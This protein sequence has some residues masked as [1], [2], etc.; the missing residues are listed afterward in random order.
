MAVNVGDVAT[1]LLLVT[2]VAV[3]RPP[4]VPVAPEA[5]AVKVTVAPFTGLLPASFTVACIAV[6]NAVL[7]VVLCGVPAV[8]VMPAAAAA[9]LVR[10]K[11]AGVATPPTE[12]VTAYDPATLLAFQNWLERNHCYVFTINGFP[13]GR[14]H[15]TRV[16]E[17]VYAPDWRTPERRDY[18][19][20]LADVFTNFLPPEVDGSIST[21]PCSFKPWIL[22]EDD[23]VMMAK[24]LAAVVAYLEIGR[25]L[26]MEQHLLAARAFFPQIV[27]H[28]LA[29]QGPD[30]RQDVIGQPVHRAA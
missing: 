30:L 20:L 17:Q 10:L 23:R 15:G 19:M 16:K 11:L 3:A 22:Q 2:T 27:G 8:A 6:A 21:V 28:V 26:A 12:A 18:T 14:F 13:Y 25:Q 4:N 7:M 1:P 24:N 5:G 29:G 9:V